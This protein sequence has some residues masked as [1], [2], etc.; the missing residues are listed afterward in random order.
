M[1]SHLVSSMESTYEGLRREAALVKDRSIGR[2]GGKAWW[3]MSGLLGVGIIT[4]GEQ[5]ARRYFRIG[6]D[7]FWVVVG[8]LF[9]AG[10]MWE[11]AQIRISMVPF[12]MILVGLAVLASAVKKRSK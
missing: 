2:L 6:L 11:L 8:V 9:L 12:L 7:G 5:A 1:A 4:L 10:G 3:N